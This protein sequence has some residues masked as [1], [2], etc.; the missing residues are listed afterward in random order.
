MAEPF[1]IIASTVGVVDFAGG[2]LTQ[3]RNLIRGW[4]DAPSLILALA[5]ETADLNTV[6]VHMQIARQT[7]NVET[8]DP[9]FVA[10]LDKQLQKARAELDLL[11][12]YKR[13]N[14]WECYSEKN[15]VTGK[16]ISC[17]QNLHSTARCT[18]ENS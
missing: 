14:R 2:L 1:S 13:L 15:K 11:D 4:K 12:N 8:I 10:A 17:V 7:A 9:E 6:L 18:R 3:I 5:N 16:E